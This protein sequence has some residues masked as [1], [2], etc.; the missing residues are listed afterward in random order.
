MFDSVLRMFYF[1]LQ[2]ITDN[3]D[4]K[5]NDMCIGITVGIVIYRCQIQFLPYQH[6]YEALKDHK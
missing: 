3:S 4:Y 1:L 2:H 5:A 6:F